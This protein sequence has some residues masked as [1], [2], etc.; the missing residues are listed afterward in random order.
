M[1]TGLSRSCRV[2]MCAALWKDDKDIAHEDRMAAWLPGC[3]A[4]PFRSLPR[5]GVDDDYRDAQR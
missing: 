3:L 4:L 2:Y 1:C 5:L